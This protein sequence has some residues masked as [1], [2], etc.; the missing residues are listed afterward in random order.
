MYYKFAAKYVNDN[1]DGNSFTMNDD[2][3]NQFYSFINGTEFE[4]KSDAEVELA[5]LR[6][7][8]TDNNYSEKVK[9]YIDI[10]DSELKS[11]RFKD[12]ESSRPIIKRMLEVEIL[13]KYN[14]PEKLI[15]ESGIKNDEQLQ[16]AL[17][18]AKDRGLYNSL[19][20]RR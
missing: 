17:S 14:R 11:E 7:E 6:K 3:A 16:V 15:T 1:P 13:R 20:A 2:V 9:T 8:T 5:R 18:I 10:L 12:F 4:F 19:L